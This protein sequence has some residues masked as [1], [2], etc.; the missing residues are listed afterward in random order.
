MLYPQNG[1]IA[2]GSCRTTP[3]APVAAAVVSDAIEAP[4]KTPCC[5]LKAP[6]TSGTVFARRPPNRIADS[7]TPRGDSH[8]GDRTGFRVAGVVKRE[9]GWA[10]LVPESGVQ[11]R[12]CQSV[13][14]WGVGPSIPS[15][16]TP[17]LSVVA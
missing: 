11:G 2:I 10:A 4:R 7:G 9:F 6:K 14:C 15:H 1:S 8:S 5:Q 13:R 12:P 17:P 3:T 16:Q